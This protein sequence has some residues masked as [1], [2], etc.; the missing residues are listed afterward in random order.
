MSDKETTGMNCYFAPME[1]ITGYV[2]RNAHHKYFPHVDG[3][4]T[5]FLSPTQNH[6]FTPKELQDIVPEHNEGLVLVPQLLP[7]K[8]EDFIWAAKELQAMGYGEVNLNL[9]C[10]SGTVTAKGKGSGFLGDIDA[11]D[12]FLDEIFSALDMEIS[13][14]T[15]LGLHSPDEIF[16]L[17]ERFNQYPIKELII[18]PRIRGD[19]YKNTPDRKRFGE[20][21][22]LSRNPVWYNGDIFTKE[23]CQRFH[24]EFPFT[25]HV[26]MGRGLTANP[27][28]AEEIKG[29]QGLKKETLKQF[30]DELY[31]GYLEV[32][33]GDKN[34]LFK[35]KELWSYL[36]FSFQECR[37]L[38]GR[39]EPVKREK[40]EKRIR[41]ANGRAEYEAAVAAIFKELE[42]K[43]GGG[44][45]S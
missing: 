5:P 45:P 38:R 29:F 30:H 23:D 42:L 1:G 40:Y 2:F 44:F 14:K 13:V 15:R 31:H 37:G 18:H 39:K 34:T 20:V 4:F 26:M 22:P 36:I 7:R 28:L 33:Q 24:E 17:M 11:L 6:R 21:L 8:A 41:K 9:G 19:F 35:M 27:A 32:I 3:Y 12:V 25:D 10:P 43:E 16:D